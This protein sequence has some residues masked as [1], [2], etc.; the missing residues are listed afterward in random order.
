MPTNNTNARR[1]FYRLIVSLALAYPLSGITFGL[2]GLA[3]DPALLFTNPASALTTFAV[4]ST[5]FGLATPMVALG[6]LKP[7]ADVPDIMYRSIVPTACIIFFLMSD[8]WG[9]FWSK[10][11]IRFSLPRRALLC[12]L[13]LL[14]GLFI[15]ARAHYSGTQSD[16]A[17]HEVRRLKAEGPINAVAWNADGSKLAALSAD[18]LNIQVWDA[19]TWNVVSA[20]QNPG[21]YNANNSLAFLPDGSLLTTPTHGDAKSHPCSLA[22]WNLAT[23]KPSREIPDGCYLIHQED[24]GRG[25]TNTYAAT[26][27]GSLIA[28]ISGNAVVII[29]DGRSGTFVRELTIPPVSE[30]RDRAVS[31]AFSPDGQTLAVGTS[32]GIVHLYELSSGNLTRS[33]QAFKPPWYSAN[34]LTY[35]PD[36]KYVAVGKYVNASGERING[37]WIDRTPD[38][39]AVTI[40]RIS[41]AT[42]VSS[43]RGSIWKL[44]NDDDAASV[45]SLSWSSDGTTLAVGDGLALRIWDTSQES[46]ALMLDKKRRQF[47]R[48]TAFSPQGILAATDNDEIVLYQ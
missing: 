11:G 9:W 10:A 39:V 36:G 38:M 45:E 24:D 40:W 14:I 3:S 28:G 29:F 34:A 33:I 2:V 7:G 6:I 16:N 41:D 23:G 5:W 26:K 47:A 19:K 31:V 42:L 25:I 37:A 4:S 32:S 8:G 43:L 17:P 48:S 13:A 15:V 12:V 44:K 46:P 1:L 18:G 27:D 20:F 21:A 35:S 22:Q 30:H